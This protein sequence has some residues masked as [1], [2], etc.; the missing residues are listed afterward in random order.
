M[1]SK[2]VWGYKLSFNKNC[3]SKK[4]Y[5]RYTPMEFEVDGMRFWYDTVT[6]DD[7]KK[8]FSVTHADS[9]IKITDLRDCKVSEIADRMIL[10]RE[11]VQ[12]KIENKDEKTLH[13]SMEKM[14][15]IMDYVSQF[16][17]AND[18]KRDKDGNYPP[19][20]IPYDA[21]F[22]LKYGLLRMFV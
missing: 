3:G 8:Y 16:D 19:E 2:R 18:F 13:E 21:K 15:D 4:E 1:K 17:S 11:L 7:G 10:Y 22:E 12:K 14:K 9:G 20:K 6:T 5:V